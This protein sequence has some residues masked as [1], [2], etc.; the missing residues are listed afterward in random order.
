MKTLL[1]IALLALSGCM[2][3]IVEKPDGTKYKFN[4][5]LYKV[6]IDEIISKDLTVKKYSSDPEKVKAITPYGVVETE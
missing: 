2:Q 1:L 5:F 6:D 4:A 3:V